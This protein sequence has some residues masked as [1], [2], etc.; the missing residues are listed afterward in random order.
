MT[1]KEEVEEE[2]MPEFTS[3]QI[4]ATRIFETDFSESQ[5]QKLIQQTDA[6]TTE[7]AIEISILQNE[8]QFVRPEQKLL[9]VDIQANESPDN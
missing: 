4:H 7:E 1:D 2:Q 9:A 3:F 5:I 8:K 6:D